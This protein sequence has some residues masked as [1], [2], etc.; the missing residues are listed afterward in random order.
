[1]EMPGTLVVGLA[2]RL[3]E[4]LRRLRVCD[5]T[6][7]CD[8]TGSVVFGTLHTHLRSRGRRRLNGAPRTGRRLHGTPRSCGCV[9]DLWVTANKGPQTPMAILIRGRPRPCGGGSRDPCRHA[10]HRPHD[11]PRPCGGDHGGCGSRIPPTQGRRWRTLPMLASQSSAGGAHKAF[12]HP[13]MFR[14]GFHLAMEPS[15]WYSDR[16]SVL[17]DLRLFMHKETWQ[18]GI[19]IWRGSY[20]RRLSRSRRRACGARHST[21]TWWPT[22]ARIRRLTPRPSSSRRLMRWARPAAVSFT[23]RG[24]HGR[25]RSGGRCSWGIRT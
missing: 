6:R 2:L 13:L 4:R 7:S 22:T 18:C 9:R 8:G 19:A 5:R 24:W 15:F 21:V 10:A 17:G 11:R 25:G 3:T 12:T 16:P 1:M 23:S 14:R 20:C